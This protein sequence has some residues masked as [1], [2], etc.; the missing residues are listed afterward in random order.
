MKKLQR[1]ARGF[2][3]IELLVVIAIIGI[4]SSVVLVSLNTARS[5]G[6][7]A[8]ILSDVQQSRILFESGFNGVVYQDIYGTASLSATAGTLTTN[9]PGYTNLTTLATDATNNSGTV[10][11]IIATNSTTGSATVPNA[12]AYA[13]YGKLASD[14]TKY[15]CIDSTGKTNP[16]ATAATAI[17]CP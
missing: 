17:T 10:T 7:D 1:R 5:K 4:L 3:L 8:R 9:G 6:K 16:T 2:T 12:T 11:Y 14:A 13:I 15:F